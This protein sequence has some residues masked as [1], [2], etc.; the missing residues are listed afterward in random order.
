MDLFLI[1]YLILNIEKY[2]LKKHDWYKHVI[3][4]F[5]NTHPTKNISVLMNIFKDEGWQD[6]LNPLSTLIFTC[7]SLTHTPN[8]YLGGCP[9]F[10]VISL[11]YSNI[12]KLTYSC[13]MIL[14][15]MN[16][17]CFYL[18]KRQQENAKVYIEKLK[19]IFQWVFQ[20]IKRA[21]AANLLHISIYI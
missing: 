20:L 8:S 14:K 9:L 21:M 5:P 19:D 1:S 13:N 6:P 15:S 16:W 18:D 7:L 11:Q 3:L 4:K 10:Y 17:V 12:S 2:V